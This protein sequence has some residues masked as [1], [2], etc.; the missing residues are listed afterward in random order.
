MN[1][2]ITRKCPRAEYSSD[3]DNTPRKLVIAPCNTTP[4]QIAESC[5]SKDSAP[6]HGNSAA[7]PEQTPDSVD[8]TCDEA[9]ALNHPPNAASTNEPIDDLEGTMSEESSYPPPRFAFIKTKAPLLSSR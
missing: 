6:L 3:D 5:K 8:D 2:S 7:N 1:L 9:A 4:Q